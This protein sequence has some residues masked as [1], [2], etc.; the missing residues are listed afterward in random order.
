VACPYST[1]HHILPAVEGGAAPEM[2]FRVCQFAD[3]LRKAADTDI[4]EAGP[5]TSSL[6][7]LTEIGL[8]LNLLLNVTECL[9]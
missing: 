5:R 1:V 3:T 2:A 8:F 4:A 7:R 9:K 6:L